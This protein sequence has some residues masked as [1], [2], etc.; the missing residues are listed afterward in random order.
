MLNIGDKIQVSGWVMLEGLED[1]AAY[2]V[3]RVQNGVYNF[4]K[5]NKDGS[6]SK[7]KRAAHLIKNVDLWIGGNN[8]NRIDIV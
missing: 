2:E 6:H 1:G 7:R 4:V 8:H 3:V 5:L